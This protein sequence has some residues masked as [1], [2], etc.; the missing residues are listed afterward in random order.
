MSNIRKISVVSALIAP[1]AL[2]STTFA[3]D[4][5][6]RAITEIANGVYRATNN[7][8]GT[9]FMV[10]DEGIVLADPINPDFSAWLRGEL[11][12][13]FGVPVRYVVYSHHHWDHASGGGA[14]ADTAQF[15]GHANMLN[16]LA[17]PPEST[18]LTDVE[19]QYSPLAALDTDADGLI[20][21][22]ETDNLRADVLA[23]LDAN[24]D[25]AVNGAELMRGPVS[26]VY[27][28]NIT[29]TDQIEISLGGKRVRMNW[30]GEMNHSL[31]SSRITFPDASVMFVVDYITFQRL[32]FMEMDFELGMYEEWMAAI[33]ETEAIARDFDHVAAGH[34]PVG[35]VDDITDWRLYFEALEAAVAAAIDAGQ[36]L[37]E[38][39]QSIE[40]PD[41]SHWAGY[42]WLD[43]NVL[44]M[45]HFLTD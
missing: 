26:R 18:R 44:G 21:G 6:R 30:V 10:T 31:D 20:S 32:P 42:N 2:A 13:R 23:G 33:R 25:G 12:R 17:L 27:P 7:N 29:Y 8:H 14:F 37:E 22:A 19:G 4:E 43:M 41:Y 15:V 3:Q 28:P 45:Y 9:V 16:H 1:L 11:D 34:G 5:P 40:I 35:T 24:G 39:Q 36:S 38:M